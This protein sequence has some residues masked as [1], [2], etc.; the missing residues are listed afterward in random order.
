[1]K[2]KKQMVQVQKQLQH[3]IPAAACRHSSSSWQH[4]STIISI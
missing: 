3:D 4:S 2:S 1:M